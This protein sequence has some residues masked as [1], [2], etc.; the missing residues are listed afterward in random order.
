[1]KEP[2]EEGGRSMGE[3]EASK[4]GLELEKLD[5]KGVDHYDDLSTC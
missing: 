1:M 5:V 3:L 2:L 4:S